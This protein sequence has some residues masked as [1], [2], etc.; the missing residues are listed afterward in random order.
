MALSKEADIITTNWYQNKTFIALHQYQEERTAERKF[1][2]SGPWSRQL[3]GQTAFL[4][5]R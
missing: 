3:V 1:S 4:N 5:R 2:D